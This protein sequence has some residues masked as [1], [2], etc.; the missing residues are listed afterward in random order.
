V[1]IVARGGGSL[2]DLWTFNEEAVARAIAACRV[3]VISAVGHETDF[4]IADFVA[5]LRAPT[6]SA[7]AE[8]VIGTRQEL[9]ERMEAIKARMAQSVRYRIAMLARGIDRRAVEGGLA[10]VHRRLGRLAQRVDD[11][12]HRMRESV[13]RALT[14]RLRAF[15]AAAAKLSQLSP[16]GVLERGYAIVSGG[17]GVLRDAAAAPPGSRI[18]VRL[19]RGRLGAVVEEN[20][21]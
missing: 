14:G 16:L 9:I 18:L 5:D 13:R 11:R 4:T 12:E 2:E 20:R 15:E 10:S 21:P 8:M 3:P 7:A 6:P 17:H 1:V 19:A